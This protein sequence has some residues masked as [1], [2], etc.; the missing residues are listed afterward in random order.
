MSR[1]A[2]KFSFGTNLL[3]ALGEASATCPGLSFLVCSSDFL[4]F[5]LVAPF[6]RQGEC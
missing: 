1:A 2:C 3:L 6:S 4:P 5:L